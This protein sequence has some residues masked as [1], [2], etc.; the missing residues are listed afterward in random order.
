MPAKSRAFLSVVIDKPTDVS[1][2]S[3]RSKRRT[4]LELQTTPAQQTTVREFN[5]WTRSSVHLPQEKLLW[6]SG[7]TTP[8]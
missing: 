3:V 7:R 2:L 4:M 8:P 6:R 1:L 5:K